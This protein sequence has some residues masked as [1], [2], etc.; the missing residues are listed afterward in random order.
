MSEA[1]KTLLLLGATSDVGRA[2]ALAFAD[3]GWDIQL[4][5]RDEEGARRNGDDIAV[6]TGA[7]VS[8]H[9]LDVLET[10]RLHA[11]LDSLPRLPDTV[12]SVVG[13]IAVQGQA[14]IDLGYAARILRTNFEG[15]ALLLG[16]IA[17]RFL[18]RGHG[19][20]VGVSS[21][22]GDRGRGANYVYGSAK[23]GLTAY[24]SGLRSRLAATD[25]RVVTVK[26]GFVR[27]RMTAA[28]KLPPVLTAEADE[29]GRAIFAA[30]ERKRGREVIYVRRIWRLVMFVISSLPEFLFK[31]L[32][33]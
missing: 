24:L 10:E 17:E 22:A 16:M 27:T 21:V 3:A 28:R 8:V 12:V 33:F 20:I 1:R 4:A 32:R 25:V 15:P 26:P 7:T 23:A 18:A 13:E 30:A 5:G 19:T 2:T 29:V 11:F 9:R 31:W 14:Q 6:R